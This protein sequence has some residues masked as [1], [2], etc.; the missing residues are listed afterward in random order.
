MLIYLD[1]PTFMDMLAYMGMN[2]YMEIC[3]YMHTGAYMHTWEKAY[4]HSYMDMLGHKCILEICGD[5]F[6]IH[7]LT[8][9]HGHGKIYMHVH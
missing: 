2:P 6:F 5:T 8:W 4:K 9:K 1:I 7:G 3:N